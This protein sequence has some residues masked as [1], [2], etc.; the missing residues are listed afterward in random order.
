MPKWSDIRALQ[1]LDI[2]EKHE[3]LWNPRIEEYKNKSARNAAFD[4]MLAELQIPDLTA[5][6]IKLKIKSI[7]TTYKRELSTVLKA[8]A[9]RTKDG[10]VYKPKLFWFHRADSFLRPVSTSRFSCCPSVQNKNES[11]DN[12]GE[13]YSITETKYSISE[14]QAALRHKYKQETL[15]EMTM[16]LGDT[17]TEEI[18][19]AQDEQNT[20]SMHEDTSGQ[21]QHH[22]EQ[23]Q[24]SIP[25]GE[26]I[27]EETI[28]IAPYRP[29][30]AYETSGTIQESENITTVT[31]TSHED[32]EYALFCR[33]VE[34][35]LRSIPDSYSRSLAKFK[36]QQV[37]FEAETGH[38]RK[39]AFVTIPNP[40]P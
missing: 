25:L 21:Q 18:S 19:S 29:N 12:S 30:D 11:Y 1:F 32:D 8:E 28:T 33:S 38:Y 6:D 22:H 10:P 20:Q 36:I 16:A 37:L 3:C 4:A 23:Q 14:N 39:T 9:N 34:A 15:Q 13:Q 27:R 31:R 24:Q 17:D 26:T 5:N 40:Q 35:Q 2:Y 7:R